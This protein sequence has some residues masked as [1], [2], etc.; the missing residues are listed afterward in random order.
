MKWGIAEDYIWNRDL[1]FDEDVYVDTPT[2]KQ[3]ENPEEGWD[4]KVKTL[5]ESGLSPEDYDKKTLYPAI[6]VTLDPS[7]AIEVDRLNVTV[8]PNVTLVYN[9]EIDYN[10]GKGFQ[11][12]L[13]WNSLLACHS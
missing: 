4:L 3:L 8:E 2:A 10:D 13:V 5:Q 9:V 6:E 12:I 11:K 7:Q 1:K